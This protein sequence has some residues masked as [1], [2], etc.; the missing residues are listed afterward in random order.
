MIY[1]NDNVTMV[2]R[3]VT[4]VW[5][6]PPPYDPINTYIT[7]TYRNDNAT[8]ICRNVHISMVYPL[9]QTI[10]SIIGCMTQ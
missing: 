6:T 9:P 5:C 3:N 4:S 7:M 2:C 8:M 10:I 1:R